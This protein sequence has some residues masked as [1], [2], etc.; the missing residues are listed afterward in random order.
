MT[1]AELY[2]TKGESYF[3]RGIPKGCKYCIKGQKVVLFLNGICQKPDHCSW[4]CPISEERKNKQITYAD[5]IQVKDSKDVLKEINLIKANGVS[6]TGGEPLAPNNINQTLDYIIFLKKKMGSNFH[7]HLYTNGVNFNEQLAQKLSLAGLDEIR[8][9]P[10]KENWNN[11]K[12]A[13]NKSMSVGAEVPVIPDK[14]NLKTLKEFI[15]YLDK[16][17]CDF[18]NLNEFEM[19]FPNSETLKSKGFLLKEG[20]IA[21]VKNSEESALKLIEN[22]A[23]KTKLN[24]HYCPIILKDH[25]QLKNRY[26]RRARSIKAPY[27]VVNNAGL[28][29][30]AQI[31]G[32]EVSLREFCDNVISKLN[33]PKNFFSFKE[34]KIYLPWYI[35]IHQKFVGELKKY[36]LECY[37]I[38][39]TPF[40]GM[41]YQI[42]EKTPISLINIFK[43]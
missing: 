13:L 6:I 4:Y 1:R 24:L 11:I 36:K 2:K 17:N 18:I 15:F 23:K 33:L 3:I 35:P 20:T 9:H 5:E 32:K 30:Y 25:Y 37:I 21:S 38:E 19:C 7:I 41:Y 16:I 14:K 10:F 43:E 26:K 31:E 12:Y 42:T 22:V 28:L 29:I 39:G 8:F 40:R 27:E 34:S